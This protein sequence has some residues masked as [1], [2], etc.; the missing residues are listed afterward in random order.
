[1]R[2]AISWLR[3]LVDIPADQSA[4]DVAERLVRAGL[5]V[6]AVD[7][8]GVDLTGPLVVGKVVSYDDEPQK[9]GKTIRWCRV[10]VGPEHN[11]DG[12]PRGIVC[13][14]SNF[15]VDDHVVVALP[16]TVLPGGFAIS[17]R[18]TYGHVSDGMICSERELGLG[19][20]HAGIM[21]LDPSEAEVGADAAA[22]LHIR[23]DVLDI[24][25]TP[26][27]GYT[28][29]VRGIARETATAYGVRFA[30][31][32]DAEPRAFGEPY[33]VRLD[34]PGC[35]AFAVV[36]VSGFDPTRPSPR[37]MRRRLQLSG[38]R[39][40]SLA[41][42]ITNY[43]MYETGQPIHGYD[44][45]KLAGTIVVRPGTP[46]EKIVTLDEVT[47][48]L[49]P[50]DMVVTDDSGP[51]GLGGVMGGSTTELSP[52]TTDVLVEAAYWDPV[53]IARTSRRH[54]L[55]S[56]ASKRFERGVD[57]A[58]QAHA[59]LRVAELL[60]ELGG[61]TVDAAGLHGA[62]PPRVGRTIPADHAAKV[63][64]YPIPAETAVA[65]LRD[66]GCVVDVSGDEL[67][68]TPPS[69]RPDLT[70]PNDFAEEVIRLEGYDTVPSVLPVAPPGRGLTTAQRLRR[71]VGTVLAGAGF[72][73]VLAYPF[74]G[75]EDFD[76]LGA[77]ADD[78]RRRTADLAN[79][80]S[81]VQPGMRTTLLPGLLTTARRNVGR[82]Q[83]DLAIYEAGL[84]FLPD[85]QLP[86]AP[87]P[88]VDKRPTEAEFDALNAALPRQP[89]HLGVVLAG[90][91]RPAG[92]WGEERAVSWADAVEAAR[93][94]ART[95]HVDLG[96]RQG[97]LA[98]WHPGRCAELV[99]GDLVV[100]HAG[101]LHPNVCKAF[102]LPARTSALELDLDQLL[103][104]APDVVPAPDFST[105]PVAKEDVALLVSVDVPVAE[106]EAALR[107]GAGELL[108]SV[109]LFDVYSGE[110]IGQ[111]QR[112]LAFALR[113]RSSD[114]TL[115]DAEIA[116]AKQSA[117]DEAARRT[118]ATQRG[119]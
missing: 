61:G 38:T 56:E 27:R 67:T 45:S 12:E 10:D 90:A 23:D 2:V 74:V 5:E 115:T 4:R 80:L 40:I 104:A 43:V 30:D 93:L 99:L 82:G 83:A 32:V 41:V 3:E 108:E 44:L 72:A 54:K 106:V 116:A 71:R 112:S 102:E 51:I 52:S 16:G 26:D 15:A 33:P 75:P 21:V 87:R 98:P 13:G 20:D 73:E 24:A 64:G 63:A 22:L 97:N 79:P 35:P 60:T 92:W 47:R 86:T 50:E 37:W 6:E 55:S 77:S 103:S 1:M 118:G 111:G 109:R 76:K 39:P 19:D 81:D 11:A 29:S 14:A 7:E 68:V 101:E 95:L 31:P 34:D 46:G 65:R 59:A 36:S 85:E 53:R 100:G 94:V 57:T 62:T 78:P 48:E 119:V 84:V 8:V 69:W 96:V 28:L 113:F 107:D 91:W 9:N 117:V 25:V 58:L 49:D 42:D 66:I 18:K 17:A 114:R 70:D 88:S 110:Q 105:Y 89:S